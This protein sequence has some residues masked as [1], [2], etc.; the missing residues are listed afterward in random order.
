MLE[1][2]RPNCLRIEY[3]IQA[4]NEVKSAAIHAVTDN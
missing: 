4:T 2:E 1:T 3:I